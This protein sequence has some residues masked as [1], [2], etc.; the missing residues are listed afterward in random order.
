[1]KVWNILKRVGGIALSVACPQAAK[2]IDEVN[3]LLPSDKQL[4]SDATGSQVEEAVMENLSPEQQA[5]VMNK[6]LD[7]ELAEIRGHS[8]DLKTL[9]D[10]DKTGNSTRPLCALI[11]MW[12]L[13]FEIVVLTVMIGVAIGN[14][15]VAS[16]KAIKDFWP[17][18]TV[19]LGIPAGIVTRYFGKRSKDKLYRPNRNAGRYNLPGRIFRYSYPAEARP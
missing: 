11:A 13:V 3:E 8:T 18:F 1:M 2:L 12:L 9:A 5:S 14:D 19:M 10:V 16:L 15:A 17:I 6:K 7:V 4:P